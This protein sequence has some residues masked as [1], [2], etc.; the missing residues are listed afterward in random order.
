MKKTMF[1]VLAAMSFAISTTAYANQLV[2]NGGF[3]TGDFSGWT[4]SGTSN[5][6]VVNSQVVHS[7]TYSA[8]LGPI[9][10]DGFLS[11]SLATQV[12]Q[13]YE[14]TYFLQNDGG[15]PNDFSVTVGGITLFSQSNIP[16]QLYTQ[17]I[18]DF[19]AT[20]NATNLTFGFR[21]DPRFFHLDDVSVATVPEPATTALLGLGLLG[22]AVS[23]RKSAK[24][25]NA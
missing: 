23:R 19:V 7:G 16:A 8:A 18:F 1:A 6:T 22:F 15:T 13:S 20:S 17:Q 5:N 2:T 4:R 9:G 21:N 3:E 25:K 14:L 11:Q 24:S 12:G 10:G